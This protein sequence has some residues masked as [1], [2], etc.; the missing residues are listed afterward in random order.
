MPKSSVIDVLIV[1]AGS[2]ERIGTDMPKQFMPLAGKSMLRRTAEIFTQHPK[3]RRVHVVIGAG[4]NEFYHNTMGPVAAQVSPPVTGGERRQDSV[5]LGLEAMAQDAPDY[6]LIVDAARPFTT[7]EVIERCI[8]Q[9]GDHA[10][11]TAVPCTD[12]LKHQLEKQLITIDRN[13]VFYAQTPQAFPFNTILE[14]H[15]RYQTQDVTD[16]MALFEKAELPIKIIQGDRRNFKITTA[17]DL[18]MAEAILNMNSETR[19]G[20]GYD[21]HRFRD[22]DHVWLGGIK[23]SHSRGVDAHSDG[24]VILHALTDALLGTIGK[25]DIGQHFPP[26]DPKWKDAA[27]D[28]FV[29]HAMQ[30]LKEA[31]GA[32]VN[33][34]I[35]VLAE[36][37]KIG[38]H[39]DAIRERIA[40]LLNT[41]IG[42]VNIKAT[43]TEKLGFVGRSEGLAAEAVV[44][45]RI[46][47]N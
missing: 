27:S 44:M 13:S 47:G 11:L 34:D 29:L 15:R 45:V 2:G 25:G 12:T 40:G 43:T 42:R 10:V 41:D 37:P 20:H 31:D 38:P 16:D 9:L 1:A 33:A 6:V 18:I 21:V 24:D 8:A 3:I 7:H 35:T 39:R 4:Q 28:Q 36:E 22:G 32:V 19:I 14:L 17:E 23:I 30:Y 5:R 26:S 46:Q